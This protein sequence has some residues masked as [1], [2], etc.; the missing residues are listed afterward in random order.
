[1]ELAALRQ[2]AVFNG[3]SYVKLATER[4][5]VDLIRFIAGWY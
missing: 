5:Q 1:M 2:H 4:C 3:I